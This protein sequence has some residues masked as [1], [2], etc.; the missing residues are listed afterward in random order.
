MKPKDVKQR[1]TGFRSPLDD[2]GIEWAE[3]EGDYVVARDLIDFLENR[4]VLYEESAYEETRPCIDSVADIRRW[5]TE[6]AHRLDPDSPLGPPL[7]AMRA[8]CRS[9]VEYVGEPRPGLGAYELR[10]AM[11]QRH[12]GEMRGVFGILVGEMAV[13]FN[14]DIGSN[15]ASMLPGTPSPPRHR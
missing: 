7:E 13:A 10:M 4:R 12:L 9:F 6:A 15:I 5:L 1:I 2:G 8:S 3:Y 14:L 11:L